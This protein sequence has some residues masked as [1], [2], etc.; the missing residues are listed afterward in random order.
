METNI[1]TIIWDEGP[2]EFMHGSSIEQMYAQ[3]EKT[4]KA[5]LTI[6]EGKHNIPPAAIEKIRKDPFAFEMQF[7]AFKDLS[8]KE[9]DNSIKIKDEQ[10]HSI[11]ENNK[12]D[13]RIVINNEPAK[14]FTE[15][16][17]DFKM[18]NNKLYKKAWIDQIEDVRIINIKTNK[19][20]TGNQY[21]IQK[22]EWIE[23]V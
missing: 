7:N 22:T 16:G 6:L 5:V 8:K 21:K 17:T 10:V 12:T 11:S 1:F 4:D 23:I 15:G 3:T 13:R 2:P 9:L 14:F 18:E 19:I 20:Y